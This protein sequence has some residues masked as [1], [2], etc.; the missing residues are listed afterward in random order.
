MKKPTCIIAV[1]FILCFSQTSLAQSTGM[2]NR[3][4]T[5]VAGRAVLDPNGDGYTSATTGGFGSSD[6]MN[7]E[8]SF[9]SVPTYS[10]EPY[11]DLRRGPNHLYSD[12]VPDNNGNG[13]YMTYTG[14]NLIFRYRVGSIMPGSKGYSIL[15]DTDSRFGATGANADPNYQAATTGTNGNPGFEIEVVLE[16][17]F[18]IGIY[19]VDGTSSPTLI[20]SYSNWQDMS[21]VSI[22]GTFD[23]GDPDFFIDFYIPFSDLTTAPFNLTTN[24]DLR[25]SATTVM[26]PQAAIGGPK[27]DIYGISDTNYPNTN[28][29][30]DVYIGSQ[31]PIKI[32]SLPGSFGPRCTTPPTVNGP[33]GTGTINISGT[34]TKSPLAG[35]LSTASITVYKN[36]VSVGT[37]SN[38][39]SGST[40]TLN[41]IALVNGDAITAK[42]Q[43]AGE[44][45]CLVSNSVIAS[46]CNSSNRP[47]T[48]I[49]GCYSTSKGITGTNLSTGW[50]VHVDNLTRN[51]VDDNLANGGGLFSA[52]TGSSPNLTWMYSNGCSSGSP[53]QSGSYKV[54]YTNNTTGCVSEPAYV[55]VAGN[56]GS[57]L[58]GA[59]AV[60]AITSPS[61][62]IFT[63]ATTSISGTT[64][65]NANL[66][67]YVNGTNVQTT[68]ASAGGAFVFSNLNLLNGQQVYIVAELTT[69]TV[70]TSKCAAQTTPVTITCFT[71]PP[72]ITT[73]NNNQITAGSPVNGSSGEPAGTV[74]K[75][76]TSGNTLVAATTMQSNG[77]WSTGNAGTTPATY[78]A[79]NAISYYATAQNGSC[80]VS[81]S[82]ANAAAVTPTSG[83]RCGTINGPVTAGS[84]SVS[85]TLATA[86]GSTFVNLYMDGINIGTI[87]TSTTNW[88]IAVSSTALYPNGT[89]TIG[90]QETGKQ[91]IICASSVMVSCSSSPATPLIS[92]AS[93]AISQ[94]QAVTYTISNAVAG[95]FYGIA[96][97]TTG[98]SLA[99]GVWA[100]SN[101]NLSITTTS[102]TSAGSFNPVVKATGLSG[103]TVC[104][105]PAASANVTVSGTLPVKFLNVSA[106]RVTDGVNVTWQ[107][108]NEENVSYY[109]V[110][111]SLDCIHFEK[112]AQVN[113]NPNNA[114]KYFFVDPVRNSSKLCYRIRQVDN[115]G[116]YLY[117]QI[118]MIKR[119]QDLVLRVVPNPVVDKANLLIES[120]KEDSGTLCLIGVNGNSIR[121]QMLQINK[122]SN[123]ILI[124]ELDHL[125]KGVY[126]IK[127][128]TQYQ[129]YYQKLMVH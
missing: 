17:N 100:T 38:I 79:V 76:Y 31:P 48:P 96:D 21:Q 121:Q 116:D 67:L 8:I 81:N 58:A 39:S 70:S 78:D 29:Q 3:T 113:Y 13:V 50:T 118:V 54:Y 60:P 80:G 107:V 1:L 92:P 109:I 4:A 73:D 62:G 94:N 69:G 93:S 9:T 15:I 49:L 64:D 95:Y 85:G 32:S 7:S 20:K 42:A 111:N 47:A 10:T 57:A 99:T 106:N 59:L 91:E 87:T 19:N 33:I 114:L 117:S 83:N 34:W 41:N 53:L 14:G 72:V 45:I 12:F 127:L 101:G 120:T 98:R 104:S 25:F 110:E 26:S 51:T 11:G 37:V 56:G 84:L 16:T 65:A 27:S 40:W 24:T 52:P 36:G 128:T 30:F 55:C 124:T 129:M 18:R 43:A 6:V 122:G 125:P 5:S 77:T 46:T 126:I 28:D 103:L 105:S 97:A 22:A 119:D 90:I 44:S 115:K 88:T 23:N 89:L 35:S 68:T 74:I 71:S 108:A 112:A 75:V 2:I 61:N 66:Y 82:S 86:V 63:T 123:S 102:F